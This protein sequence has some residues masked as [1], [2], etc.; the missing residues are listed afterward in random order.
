M[1]IRTITIVFSA[2][3]ILASCSE[4]NSLEKK[5]LKEY[6]SAYLKDNEDVVAFGYSKIK[7]I[8][9]KAQYE[10]VAMLQA[11]I[12]GQLATFEGVIN[13]DQPVYYAA[14]A[15]LNRDGA[16][17]EIVLFIEVVDDTK[18]KNHLVSEMGYDV[19]EGDG[20][21]YASDGDMTLG[22]RD[23]LLIVLVK[24]GNFDEETELS[25]AFKSV[26]G[27]SST[28]DIQKLLDSS[29]GD[30]ILSINLGNAALNSENGM[31]DL[32]PKKQQEIKK[33]FKNSYI[34]TTIKFENGQAVIETQNQFSK[35]LMSKMFFSNDQSAEVV[36][37][38]GG[39]TPIAGF[40]MNIDVKKMEAFMNYIH[41]DAM[42]KIGGM[43]YVGMKFIAG[44]ND[45]DEIIDGKAGIVF[46]APKAGE[47]KKSNLVNAFIGLESKGTKLIESA[48][49]SFGTMLPTDLPDFSVK[50]NGLSILGNSSQIGM[51]LNLPSVASDFGKSGINFFIDLEGLDPA[52]LVVMFNTKDFGP[53]LKVAKS[54]SFSYS[55]E[56]GKLIVTAKKGKENILK[57][58]LEAAVSDIS[59]LMGGVSF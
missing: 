55:N 19:S 1:I 46:F 25:K 39:G 42:T 2:L 13:L 45:L 21:S 28:G 53:I 7:D 51:K 44:A 50:N 40:S 47:F 3:F 10:K 24:P 58:A 22:I 52:D 49:S 36:N 9:N 54:L 41:P 35:K 38:L 18:L 43:K 59:E 56:G 11:I 17:E 30:V 20:F 29:E 48:T 37:H 34:N 15:P 31:K 32:N 8:L 14:N 12:G 6:F 57:Q 4:E 26:D 23:N 27:K 5:E 33:L 16:P